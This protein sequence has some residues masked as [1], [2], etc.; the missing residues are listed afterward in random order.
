MHLNKF[1]EILKN[2]SYVFLSHFL[3][4]FFARI[5]GKISI[6]NCRNII[7]MLFYFKGVTL[8]TSI[9]YSIFSINSYI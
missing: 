1:F 6:K 7:K 8:C 9:R 5:N 2:K 3:I 4:L